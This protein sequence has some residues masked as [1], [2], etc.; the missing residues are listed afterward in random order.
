MRVTRSALVLC[1]AA[2]GAAAHAGTVSVSF[3][4]SSRFADAGRMDWEK[5]ANLRVIAQHLQSLGQRHLPA[6][7]TL[8]I[9]VVDVDLAGEPQT[10]KR[11]L[12]VARGNADFPRIVLRYALESNGRAVK[13]G[14]ETVSALDYTHYV[15]VPR[16][17]EALA[18]EKRM[19]DR[20][21]RERFA[22]AAD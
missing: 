2:A 4:D 13:N 18:I 20:W 15:G 5:E 1:L 10:F 9:E 21:F 12:R 8:R 19:L 11:D 16:S 7:R 14:E 6:D 17:S 22:V 3:A